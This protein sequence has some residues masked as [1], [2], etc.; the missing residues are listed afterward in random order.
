[1]TQKTITQNELRKLDEALTDA[2]EIDRL[3]KALVA[4]K[5]DNRALLLELGE[6]LVDEQTR[7][8]SP[9]FQ[10][11]VETVVEFDEKAALIYAKRDDVFAGAASL[12]TV[13][14]DSVGVLVGM[15][16]QFQNALALLATMPE[17]DE[18]A[19]LKALFSS[20]NLKNIFEVNKTGYKAAVRDEIFSDIP[21]TSK[22]PRSTVRITAKAVKTGDELAKEFTVI[23]TETEAAATS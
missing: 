6:G 23:E 20:V 2:V 17:T 16:L 13:R 22:A 21:Y 3:E 10:I 1:M 4:R 9:G 18:T 19:A 15:T 12:L 8:V 14:P 11:S 7:T 5:E